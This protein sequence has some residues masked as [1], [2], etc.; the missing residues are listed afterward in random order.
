MPSTPHAP[1]T[2]HI[3]DGKPV[4]YFSTV[5]DPVI[6]HWIATQQRK[7]MLARKTKP[8]ASKLLRQLFYDGCGVF[9][10]RGIV[11][12]P[13]YPLAYNK[14]T[15]Q[16]SLWVFSDVGADFVQLCSDAKLTKSELMYYILHRGAR[17]NN[18]YTIG[19]QK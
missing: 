2:R 11:D 3:Y 13:R 10:H 7:A 5:I 17:K 4:K 15:E 8:T 12:I 6:A 18:I 9:F 19:A 14:A 1:S 16:A